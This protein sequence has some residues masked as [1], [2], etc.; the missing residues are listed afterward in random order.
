MDEMRRP[1]PEAMLRKF[2]G[3]GSD[4]RRG[5][6]KIFFGACAGVGKTYAML[7]SARQKRRDGV[8]VL[9]G[10]VETHGRSETAA[11]L[12][13]LDVFP[14]AKTEYRGRSIAEL[15]LEGL[16]SRKPG[17]VLVDE[18]AHTNIL[19]LRH[20]KRWQDVDE[21]LNAGIDV[22]TTMNVQHL[23]SLN[24]VVGQITGVRVQETVPDKFFEKADEIAL[25]DL[26]PEELI[27]RMEEGK[28]YVP[29]QARVAVRSFFRKGNLIALRELALRRTADSVDSKMQDYR[30]SRG[31]A[32]GW[33]IKERIL[34]CIG[35]NPDSERL[36]RAASR[37]GLA[38]HAEWIAV[39][40]ETPKLTSLPV[41]IRS[42]IFST[43]RR[44]ENLG[45][46]TLVI[47]GTDV[48]RTLV[49]FAKT[50]NV[51]SMV[52]GKVRKKGLPGG[53]R[54]LMNE[55]SLLDPSLLLHVI[56]DEPRNDGP[57]K[58]PKRRLRPVTWNACG[59]SVAVIAIATLICA[60]LQ[61]YFDIANIVMI[62]LLAVVLVA[63][64]YGRN[65]GLFTA[66]LG[67]LCFDV[68]FVPP[69]FSLTVQDSRHLVT[70]AI[71]LGVAALV[72]S[73]TSKL[74]FQAMIATRREHRA[75]ILYEVSHELAKS[76]T[77]E[78]TVGI[79]VRHIASIF[80]ADVRV[81]LPDAGD[82]LQ[83]PQVQNIPGS[84]PIDVGVAQWSFEN[85]R[86]AGMG[87][88]TLSNGNVRYVPLLGTMRARGVVA[89]AFRSPDP[90]RLPEQERLLDIIAT[91]VG[92]TLERIHF[93]E[94][95]QDSVVRME[96][97]RLRNMLLASVSHDIRTPLAALVGE[98]GNLLTIQE[99]VPAGIRPVFQ[100]VHEDA[101]RLENIVRN[102]LDMAALQSGGI[103]LKKQWQPIEEIIGVA[104]TGI[105]KTYP[106]LP[107]DVDIP[108]RLPLVELDGTLFE[109]VLANLL[110]NAAKYAGKDSPVLISVRAFPTEM[111]L[112]VRDRGP[113]VPETMRRAIF[114]KFRRG[115][116]ESPTPG[117]GLGLSICEAIM[118]A[119]G[120]KIWVENNPFHGAD[121]IVSIP[122][123]K[124]PEALRAEWEIYE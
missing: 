28:V 38:L 5:H 18:L 48:P 49:S 72:G 65:P 47:S 106:A 40:V 78:Q 53:G 102:I 66:A 87:T 10:V 74:R 111:R 79:A 37:I 24:D 105:Q 62:Y 59:F 42:R 97:E 73:L 14:L 113:G 71:M 21:L 7:Q 98:T 108:E 27:S 119:H 69:R 123:T 117:V 76:L 81:L 86:S 9:V 29:P 90:L 26:P 57:E 61:R 3:E 91:Q 67:V 112:S 16:L 64:R 75:D 77:V 110:N 56:G 33:P 124:P 96:T 11:L 68:F 36:V 25:I 104:V 82:R 60:V 30:T 70:F 118:T 121:F 13:G 55:I 6:L 109:R 23:D 41:E 45:A 95:A 100:R 46:Q 19:G 39:Y 1:D 35:P 116:T 20:K 15:D 84:F 107:V 12:E 2:G 31:I 58:A 63:F 115:E 44:A 101:E 80:D 22:Y 8:D 52:L 122:L 32:R 99:S 4:M 54:D 85:R 50:R 114:E 89:V 88:D 83:I 93:I 34:V 43:L 120:G 17:L 94:V 51:T 103:H 92:Q